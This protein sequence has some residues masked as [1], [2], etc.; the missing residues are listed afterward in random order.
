M[1][2]NMG[3]SIAHSLWQQCRQIACF[4]V[5]LAEAVLKCGVAFAIALVAVYP[6]IAMGQGRE[7]MLAMND[8]IN[9]ELFTMFSINN[10]VRE[11]ILAEHDPNPLN[12]GSFMLLLAQSYACGLTFFFLHFLLS[13]WNY[14]ARR[15]DRSFI[16]IWLPAALALSIG[17]LYPIAAELGLIDSLRWDAKMGLAKVSFIL[18]ALLIAWRRTTPSMS[19]SLSNFVAASVAL[20]IFI[21]FFSIIIS[22]RWD[23]RMG[24]A[25]VSVIFW[26][27]LTAWRE[28]TPSVSHSLRIFLVASSVLLLA[29]LIFGPLLLFYGFALIVLTVFCVLVRHDFR[30]QNPNLRTAVTKLVGAAIGVALGAVILAAVLSRTPVFLYTLFGGGAPSLVL[31]GF[32]FLIAIAYGLAALFGR[33]SP[34]LVRLA[35]LALA[36]LLILSPIG[37][38]PLRVLEDQRLAEKRPLPSDHFV[39]WF[40]A[41]ADAAGASEEYPVFFVA[42]QGGGVRAAY[43]TSTLLAALEE[44]Y[45]GFTDHVYAVS[46]VSG[47]SVGAAVFAAMYSE[48]PARGDEGCAPLVPGGIHGL[49]PCVAYVFSWDLLGPT[50]GTLLFNDIPFGWLQ[51]RRARALEQSLELAWSGSVTSRA[52]EQPLQ[53]LWSQD[54]YRIPSLILNTTS[55]QDGHRIVVSNLRAEGELTTEADVEAQLG[56]PVRLSTAV[57]LSARFPVI[58]PEAT[59]A[60][61]DGTQTRFMRLVDGGYFNN[62]GTASIASLLRAVLPKINAVPGRRIKPIVLVLASDVIDAESKP[63]RLAGSLAAAI[64]EPVAVLARTG[65]AHEATYVREIK[66]LTGRKSIFDMRPPSGSKEVALGWLLSDATRCEM[67]QMVNDVVNESDASKAIAGALR[68]SEARTLTWRSCEPDSPGTPSQ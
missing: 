3:Q 34:V 53:S 49:R 4:L 47:G 9:T 29:A 59:F 11:A 50:V 68:A 54:A 7:A 67:D 45:P 44:R 63:G 23:A 41:R 57:F 14:R 35:W 1:S 27:V 60:V 43:W 51:R 24:L 15:G 6:M 20:L 55:A 56:H 62:A 40:R 26:A 12:P 19:H 32:S 42:A 39:A 48:L 61:T 64:S 36:A 17:L 2:A 13:E 33:V 65:S 58:S 22:L 5:S 8:A 18:G 37:R 66:V 21:L 28:T 38:E 52:F 10:Q 30:D 31:F 46:G 16:R 25:A